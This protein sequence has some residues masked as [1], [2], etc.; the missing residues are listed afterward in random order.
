MTG[1][2]RPEVALRSKELFTPL[3]VLGRVE[4]AVT[5]ASVAT[6]FALGGFSWWWLLALFLVFD[7]SM[8]GYLLG[9]RLGALLYNA[10]HNYAPPAVLL[11]IYF[12]GYLHDA[13]LRPLAILAAAW[14]FHIGAD[15]ALG[16]G[17]RPSTVEPAVV[18]G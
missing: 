9:P 7:L 13:S 2:K 12:A 14:I 10:A 18:V 16:F 11:V 8:L 15:R 6:I 1:S 4:G 3:S 5:A 17:P